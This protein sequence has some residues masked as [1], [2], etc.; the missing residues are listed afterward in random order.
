[1]PIRRIDLTLPDAP[2]RLINL[3]EA[4]G[5]AA[6]A[7]GGSV[8]DFLL[9]KTPDDWD[10]CTGALPEQVISTLELHGIRHIETGLQHGTI[11][12][13][14]NHQPV[15]ITTFRIDGC[16]SDHRRPDQVSFTDDL[17]A[18]LSRRDFTVNAIA[19]H[20]AQGLIDPFDGTADLDA[21]L[22][23]C[24]GEPTCR[25]TE[26]ALRILRC[27]RFASTLQFEI[28]PVTSAA[29]LDLCGSLCHV[30]AERIQAEL[31]KLL[32]GQ[33]VRKILM[34]YHEVIFSVLPQLRPMFGFNQHTPWHCYDVW[35]HTCAAVEAIQPDPL[36]R[37]VAFLHDSGK[38]QCFFMRDGAGHFYGHADVSEQIARDIFSQLKCSR[39]FTEQATRLI[40]YHEMRMLEQPPAPAKLRRLLGKF[41]FEA[42]LQLL[43][44]ARADVQAQAPEKL[45]RLQR[46]PSMREEIFALSAANAC[47]TRKDLAINGSDLLPLG[48]QGPQLGEMLD[49]LLNEVIEDRLQNEREALL[50]RARRFMRE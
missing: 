8:R 19:Y 10:I 2:L 29:L 21:R 34:R 32:C 49:R 15:E 13:L 3:L 9:G 46:Y 37:W 36:L 38:P 4:A 40:R 26:D 25:F 16:Y 20:P 31:T 42:L 14:I 6:Y 35:E 43:E 24:V 45:Y 17:T 23:R 28:E 12:A 18:D 50:T 5:F 30:A 11:T 48:L 39:R 27:L 22:L 41:G 33:D 1:M 7:V 44:L 47:V